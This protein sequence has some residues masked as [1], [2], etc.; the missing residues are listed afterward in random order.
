MEEADV[1]MR[2]EGRHGGEGGV[3]DAERGLTVV[4]DL[5][6]VVAERQEQIEDLAR[7]ANERCVRSEPGLYVR[8]P[9]LRPLQQEER[10]HAG[11]A[12]QRTLSVCPGPRSTAFRN[13][14]LAPSSAARNVGSATKPM[15]MPSP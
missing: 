2:S 9:A 7:K 1:H 10:A 11:S 6:H 12:R 4:H 14:M 3:A 13:T 15:T 5:Q 8:M